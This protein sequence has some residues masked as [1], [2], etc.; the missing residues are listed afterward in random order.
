MVAQSVA[1]AEGFAVLNQNLHQ[2]FHVRLVC[3]LLVPIRNLGIFGE[4]RITCDPAQQLFSMQP[5]A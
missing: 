2:I 3:A 1:G 4:C 5:Y